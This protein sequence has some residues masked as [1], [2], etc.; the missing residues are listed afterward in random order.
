MGHGTFATV[1]NCIDGRAK[2]PVANWVKN[3]LS[4][5]YVD[6][7]TEPGPDKILTEGTPAQLDALKHNVGIS[8]SAHHS[9]VVVIA[10]HHD[11][12]GNP[13]SDEE[14][15]RQVLQSVEIVK[16]W[17]LNV[18]R[19]IGIWLN[20]QWRIEVLY[21][22]GAQGYVPLS[23]AT[24]ITCIDGRAQSPL[25][26]WMK[27]H[28][29]VHHVDLITEPEVDS[30]IVRA[31]GQQLADLRRKIQYSLHEHQ[32]NLVIV[33]AH[34][35]CAGGTMSDDDRKRQLKQATQIVVA[36][37]LPVRVVGV[38]LNDQWQ[39]EIVHDTATTATKPLRAVG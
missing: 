3:N 28:F 30:Y 35:D 22:D 12:A 20:D 4:V 31:T 34:H 5:H 18:T 19:I 9:S 38:W 25:A 17:N 39:S 6:Q 2:H 1:I 7:I 11:C 21:D 33:S 15:H 23:Y 27:Q 16:S 36:F 26:D 29:F 32:S 24:A 10:A 8:V 37:E 14:H 13:V